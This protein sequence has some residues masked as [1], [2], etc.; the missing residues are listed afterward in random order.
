VLQ[1]INDR[2]LISI[3]IFGAG[4]AVGIL[5]FSRFLKW[6]FSRYHDVTIAVLS[7][8]LLGSLNKLWPWKNTLESFVKHE[9]EPN[10]KIVPIV[11]ENIFPATYE[12]LTNE[13]SQLTLA[14]LFAVLGVAIIFVLDR[15]AP[16]VAAK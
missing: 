9:G 15:F 1:A 12:A 11:Q 3:A 14:I 7:G 5:S 10:E 8:F 6:M 2:N 4:C 16:K 13:P